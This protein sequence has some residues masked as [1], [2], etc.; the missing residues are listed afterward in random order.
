[1]ECLQCS[2]RKLDLYYIILGS[3]SAIYGI[4]EIFGIHWYSLVFVKVYG[5]HELC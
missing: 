5:I 4:F 2:P 1:M 3:I